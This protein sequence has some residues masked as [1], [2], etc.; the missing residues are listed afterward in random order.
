MKTH[1]RAFCAMLGALVLSA[2][3]A[4]FAQ[5]ACGTYQVQSGDTI[6]NI[7]R[8]AFNGSIAQ[9]GDIYRINRD[10]VGNDADILS[11]GLMLRIPCSDGSWSETGPADGEV[12]GYDIRV[13]PQ[14]V[15]YI[16]DIVWWDHGTDAFIDDIQGAIN[17]DRDTAKNIA[18]RYCQT[19][20]HDREAARFQ[21]G[22][23]L[24]EYD[25]R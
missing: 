1:V 14:C 25:N 18:R 23:D 22:Q 17:V 24:R 11:P 10:V 7:S 16:F 20:D 4:G 5:Q 21:L 2:P 9:T 3:T 12:I 19:T 13:T 6:Y 8:R 15:K